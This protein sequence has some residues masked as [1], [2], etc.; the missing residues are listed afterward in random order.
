MNQTLNEQ[1][2]RIKSMME[3]VSEPVS[4][5]CDLTKLQGAGSDNREARLWDKE[6]ARQNKAEEKERIQQNKNFMSLAYDRDA[7]PLDKSA[8]KEYYT[9]YQEFMKSNP[10][11]LSSSD[12][13]SSEQKYAIASK[14][15]DFLRNVPRISYTVNLGSKFGLNSK[16]TVQNVNDVIEKMG[17]YD[18]YMEWFNAGGPKFK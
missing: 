4:G 9:Q 6:V 13:Y 5:K 2:Q 10:S 3:Q 1:I 12:G 15:L 11:L 18:V 7:F 8:R 17:G 14:T 16:S